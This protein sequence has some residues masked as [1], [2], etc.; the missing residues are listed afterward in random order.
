MPAAFIGY[1][2]TLEELK[3]YK[4][5][6]KEYQKVYKKYPRNPL[7]AYALMNAARCEALYGNKEEAKK[8]YDLIEEK[9]KNVNIAKFAKGQKILLDLDSLRY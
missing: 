3:D 5:A 2:N 8:I 9:Y 4:N 7:A 1:A 6:S